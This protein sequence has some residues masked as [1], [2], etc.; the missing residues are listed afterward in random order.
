MTVVS[1]IHM[2]SHNEQRDVEMCLQNAD[3][4]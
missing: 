2:I 4:H 1:V 3:H